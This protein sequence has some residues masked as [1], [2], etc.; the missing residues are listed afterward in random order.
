MTTTLKKPRLYRYR[1]F[2]RGPW[3]AVTCPTRILRMW[4]A[5]KAAV[6]KAHA[7]LFP[8]KELRVER[9]SKELGRDV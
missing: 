9:I 6:I 5:N 7:K 1:I 3:D 2:W 4:A 8:A